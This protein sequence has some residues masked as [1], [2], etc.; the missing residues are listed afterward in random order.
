M[1]QKS[2]RGVATSTLASVGLALVIAVP[3]AHGQQPAEKSGPPKA[4]EKVEQPDPD[5]QAAAEEN[6]CKCEERG[7]T[8]SPDAHHDAAAFGFHAELGGLRLGVSVRD[9]T[10]EDVE[11]EKLTETSGA[12]VTEVEED[13]PAATGGLLD[14]D[15]IVIFDGERVRSA[16]QLSRLVRETPAEREVTVEVVRDGERQRLQVA[17]ARDGWSWSL[18]QKKLRD[19]ADKVRVDDIFERL[20]RDIEPTVRVF[21]SAPDV[22]EYIA[23][24]FPWSGARLGVSVQ[25]LT[26]QLA[27]Y[28]R[29]KSGVLI[30]SVEADSPA[31]KAGLKAGDVVT[32]VDG[33]PV[34]DV[35]SIRRAVRNLDKRETTLSVT[36][37]GQSRSV[38]VTFP[39]SSRPTYHEWV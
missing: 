2:F 15:V 18:S 29:V 36:R 14:G 9:V 12:M 7:V 17:P 8:R 6:D 19:L 39:E 22:F 24:H 30:F 37:D 10:P 31:A 23:P 21:G 28:F 32:A 3:V 16:R 25:P 5:G 13:S 4:E 27:E 26:P 38:K 35:A 11:N 1:K 20:Q 34:D 33:E